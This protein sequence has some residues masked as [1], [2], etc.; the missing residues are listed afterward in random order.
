M[1]YLLESCLVTIYAMFMHIIGSKTVPTFESLCVKAVEVEWVFLCLSE[2][3]GGVS[4]GACATY[5]VCLL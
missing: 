1:N 3:V 2:A 5:A 4:T